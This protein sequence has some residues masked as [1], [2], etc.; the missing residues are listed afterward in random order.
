MCEP[1]AGGVS[2]RLSP[3]RS[4]WL[5]P[6]RSRANKPAA[7]NPAIAS[8]LLVRRHWRGIGEPERSAS[9][10]ALDSGAHSG[11]VLARMA[12]E[13]V[14]AP[15]AVAD[16]ER[17]RAAD[18][19][20][21]AAA[22]ETHLRHAPRTESK[23]RIKRLRGLRQPERRLRVADFRVFYDVAEPEVHILAIVARASTDEW[24]EQH[25]STL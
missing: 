20:G 2:W 14:F 11:H 6:P 1:P 12:Y 10:G 9:V 24:L 15:E 3:L 17:L 5:V 13:I 18:R 7:P 23:S 21:I 19:S 4:L 22:I 25:A 8:Q 16:L